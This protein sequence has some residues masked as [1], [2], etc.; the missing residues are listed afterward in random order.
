VEVGFDGY[1]YKKFRYKAVDSREHTAR[2]APVFIG[3]TLALRSRPAAAEP[4][5]SWGHQVMGVFLGVVG[6]AVVVVV[7]LTW[8]Y[9][10][11]DARVRRRLLASRRTELVLPPAEDGGASDFSGPAR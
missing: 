5:E 1:F 6:L 9:R 11:A 2:D 8:W 7:G 4:E 10:R 3:H